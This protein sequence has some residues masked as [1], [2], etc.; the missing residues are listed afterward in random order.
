[1]ARTTFSV[2]FYINRTRVTKSGET[3]ILL[4]VTTRGSQ[5][6]ATTPLKIDLKKWNKTQPKAS[7][8]VEI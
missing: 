3:S 7:L 6:V 2:V 1:M 4:R 5:A 8:M